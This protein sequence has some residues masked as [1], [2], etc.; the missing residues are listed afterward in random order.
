MNLELACKTSFK[1][2]D[3]K[4]LF[5]SD[6][7]FK[8]DFHESDNGSV[9]ANFQATISMIVTEDCSTC[10]GTIVISGG[11]CVGTCSCT[12]VSSPVSGVSV[13]LGPGTKSLVKCTQIGCQRDK[14]Y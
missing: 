1:V 5:N 13:R 14:K 8:S 4:K 11:S 3:K 6:K 2:V 9:N 10:F 12:M 7:S